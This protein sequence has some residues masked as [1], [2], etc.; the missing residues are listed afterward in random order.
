VTKPFNTRELIARIGSAVRRHEATRRLLA[1]DRE[2]VARMSELVDQTTQ[3]HAVVATPPSGTPQV[4]AV[5]PL[6]LDTGARSVVLDGKRV[7]LSDTELEVLRVLAVHANRVV[8]RT[9]IIEQIWG[10]PTRE[11]LIMLDAHI[12]CIREKIE[13]DPARPKLLHTVPGIGFELL[14]R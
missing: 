9:E 12:R 14:E 7:A 11:R 1:D 2:L 3:P 10:S 8:T 4:I 5:G 6:V 13:K